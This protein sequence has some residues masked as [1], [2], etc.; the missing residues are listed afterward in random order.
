MTAAIV[1]QTIS[2]TFFNLTGLGKIR[3]CYFILHLFKLIDI[4]N[5]KISLHDIFNYNFSFK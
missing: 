1:S 4:P 2:Q 3:I 5:S